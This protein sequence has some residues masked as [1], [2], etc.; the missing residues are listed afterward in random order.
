MLGEFCGDFRA[1]FAQGVE[2][3]QPLI[4][5]GAEQTLFDLLEL[6]FGSERIGKH[7]VDGLL[8]ADGVK[9]RGGIGKYGK[10]TGQYTIMQRSMG[11]FSPA[12]GLVDDF[13]RQQSGLGQCWGSSIIGGRL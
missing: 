12:S 1:L 4:G 13:Q 7:G 2:R 3:G 10:Q 9:Q 8:N 5:G 6:G 11:Q